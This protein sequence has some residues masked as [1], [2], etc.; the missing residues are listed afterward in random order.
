MFQVGF[1]AFSIRNME[2]SKIAIFVD[3]PTEEGALKAK[4]CK[5]YSGQHPEFRYGPGN[6]VDYAVQGYANNVASKIIFDLNRNIHVVVLIPDLEKRV[7]KHNIDCNSFAVQI[8]EAVVATIA[9]KGH[10]SEEYLN[11]VI[12][13]CP[14]DIMFENWIVC[15]VQGIKSH[16]LIK[17]DSKQEIYEGMNGA[18]ILNEMM[19]EKYK[20]TVHAKIL[21]KQI[22]SSRGTMH[23]QSYSIFTNTVIELIEQ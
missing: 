7:Q 6:G 23:S 2:L 16:E 5:D 3:G 4:F 9:A 14:S 13:V 22:D 15:D 1:L 21:Y 11:T 12:F 8:K 10:F 19:T 17:D 18:S 20:K